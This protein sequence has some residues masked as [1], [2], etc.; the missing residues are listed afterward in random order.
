MQRAA[1]QALLTGLRAAGMKDKRFGYQTHAS[2][3]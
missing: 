1:A 3:V 2:L